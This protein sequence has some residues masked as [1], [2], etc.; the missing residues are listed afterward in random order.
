M[1]LR[2][3]LRRDEEVRYMP[4]VDSRGN[5]TIGAGTKLPLSDKEVDLLLFHRLGLVLDELH[6]NLPWTA[7]LDE[8]R[9]NALINMAYNMG[10]PRLLTF[11]KMLAAMEA[12][13][14]KVAALEALDS[15]WYHQV[16]PRATRL[17]KQ[18]ETGIMQ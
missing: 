13:K 14:W 18:I 15:D 17:A 6:R 4:Y 10:V 7:S 3:Q 8:A 9:A 5:P 2:E 11:V 16:G 1:T 12:G